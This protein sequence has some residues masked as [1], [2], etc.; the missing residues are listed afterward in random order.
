V[1]YT[2]IK[3]IDESAFEVK[4]DLVKAEEE[5]V[6]EEVIA[7]AQK[8]IPTLHLTGAEGR[9]EIMKKASTEADAFLFMILACLF[10]NMHGVPPPTGRFR[11]E[12]KRDEA[13]QKVVEGMTLTL[14]DCKALSTQEIPGGLCPVPDSELKGLLMTIRDASHRIEIVTAERTIAATAWAQMQ[15]DMV[16]WFMPRVPKRALSWF[17]E[18]S[19]NEILRWL[20]EEVSKGAFD[21]EDEDEGGEAEEEEEVEEG[22]VEEGV[23]DEEREEGGGGAGE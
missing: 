17:T 5:E 6:W 22:V 21:G 4:V 13:L 23:V 7:A 10:L 19:E 15:T 18:Y 1:L 12:D 9:M 8:L 16:T 14:R 3:G 11:Q 2:I 20:R